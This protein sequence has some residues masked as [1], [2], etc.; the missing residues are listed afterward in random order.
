MNKLWIAVFVVIASLGAG[1]LLFSQSNG[2]YIGEQE[3]EAMVSD[4]YSGEIE[5]ISITEDEA[6]YI[7]TVNDDTHS[8]QIKIDRDDSTVED[9]QS[10]ETEQPEEA[11]TEGTAGE[12]S[13]ESSDETSGEQNAENET[14]EEAG[15]AEEETLISDAEA[16]DIAAQ[17]VG[18]WYIYSS[19][20]ENS[21]PGVYQVIQ[22]VDDDEGA[23][24]TINAQNGE[25]T[26]LLWFEKEFDEVADFEAFA[27]QL[28]EYNTQYQNNHYIEFD[29]Y[30]DDDDDD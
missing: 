11:N 14:S 13:E 23:L 15:E 27:Q 2:S 8:Y 18:G 9:I 6:F 20:N 3:A 25:V 21:H 10:E 26:K 17:E 12:P 7:V 5:D 28:R 4:R 30:D 1:V 29:D 24:V 22:G 19:L 16:R